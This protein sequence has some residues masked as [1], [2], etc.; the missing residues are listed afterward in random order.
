M[1]AGAKK[2]RVDGQHTGGI[3]HWKVT[4]L[5]SRHAPDGFALY[6]VRDFMPVEP[7]QFGLYKCGVQDVL[8]ADPGT[9]MYHDWDPVDYGV[10]DRLIPCDRNQPC[11][12][13]QFG[14][15]TPRVLYHDREPTGHLGVL[16]TNP[17]ITVAAAPRAAGARAGRVRQ[18]NGALN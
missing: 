18:P 5:L 6:G 17:G 2:R 4:T 16:N 7:M 15:P 12:V 13:V 10:D 9:W 14:E 1:R 8:A 3:E 11:L